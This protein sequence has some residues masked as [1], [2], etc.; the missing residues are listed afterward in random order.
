[1]RDIASACEGVPEPTHYTHDRRLRGGTTAASMVV[2]L[3]YHEAFQTGVVS[4][5]QSEACAISVLVRS[6]GKTPRKA[7]RLTH[8]ARLNALGGSIL[9]AVQGVS[10]QEVDP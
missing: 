5:P 3:P 10:A 8:S 6:E 7:L 4:N 9:H 1:M 2:G